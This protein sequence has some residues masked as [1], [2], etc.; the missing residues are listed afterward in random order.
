[1]AV[2]PIASQNLFAARS[3]AHQQ[4]NSLHPYALASNALCNSVAPI[5]PRCRDGSTH[6]WNTAPSSSRF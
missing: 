1:M 2:Y 5:K 6:N 4:Q 3:C